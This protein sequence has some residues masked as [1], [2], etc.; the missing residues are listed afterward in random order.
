MPS[1]SYHFP[2]GFLW[3]TATS[4][5]QVEGKNT[6]N[7]WSEWENQ[8]G[9]ILQ[10]Q[11]S[12]LACDW[13]GGRWKEDFDRARETNQNAHR[14]SLEW[15]RIQPASDR[16]DEDALDYYRQMIR[17][18]VE[19][20]I[21]PM[22]TL[23]HFT[24]PLWLMEMGGWE[25]ENTPG[26]FAAYVRKVV[27][28]LKDY[29][30]LWVT[31]NEPNV[32]VFSGYLTGSKPTADYGDVHT[33]NCSMVGSFPPGKNDQGAALAVISNMVRGHAAA[34]RVIHEIQK[35]AWVGTAIN[36][37]GVKAARPGFPPDQWMTNMISSN[38]NTSFFQALVNGK[39]NF[40]FKSVSIP[41][42]AKTQDYI[43]VN[44]YTTDLVKFAPVAFNN[45]FNRRC[46]SRDAELSGNHFIANEP[47]GIFTALKWVNKLQLPIYVT[48]NGVED[49]DDTLRPRY[50]LEHLHQI[51]KAV[52]FNYPIKGYFHWS[53]VDNFEWE[54]GW[55]Q[56]F[57][58]WGL[59]VETQARVRRQS[60][61]LYSAIC[62]EN[63]ITSDMVDKYAR[64]IM[65]KL[66]PL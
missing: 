20:K 40:L 10:G 54:R 37:R 53:L 55:T 14:L 52:N 26:L 31:I 16:W 3:G 36:W 48:E 25:N 65:E 61:D 6:N 33:N 38:F 30:T 64:P 35:D 23:H 50:T 41:E 22:V 62:K 1:I 56:R 34:Y 17:G 9:N 29:V 28:A 51:W 32:Y 19:R 49:A 15:S 4:S 47:N 57:G 21:T 59:N 46:Y 27:Q 45:L 58:L 39:L 5:H 11:H 66:F 18:L 60:V 13:W 43:G 44:Y 12:G 8:P 2:A 42:A 63:G 7:N 24:D